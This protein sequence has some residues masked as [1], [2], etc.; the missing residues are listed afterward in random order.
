M[1]RLDSFAPVLV[2]RGFAPNL[3]FGQVDS[4]R[5]ISPGYCRLRLSSTDL[6]RFGRDALHFRLL[7]PPR[8]R[9]PVWPRMG[10]DGRTL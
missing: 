6:A 1:S 9:P 10:D 2:Q 4:L 7:L 8:D 3:I 5:Q